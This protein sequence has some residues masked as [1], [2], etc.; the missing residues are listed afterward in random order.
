MEKIMINLIDICIK[1]NCT[2]ELRENL[3]LFRN[4][5]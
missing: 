3:Q 5:F 2:T 1:H 4:S